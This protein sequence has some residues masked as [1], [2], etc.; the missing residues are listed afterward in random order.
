MHQ[1]EDGPQPEPEPC[2]AEF[3]MEFVPH[4]PGGRAAVPAERAGKFVWMIA[5]GQMT[6]Q[7]F[8]EMRQY[9]QHIVGTGMW[10][11]NWDG[12]P[13]PQPPKDPQEEPPQ[14]PSA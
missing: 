4:L 11:Q 10:Q 2:K 6:E 12:K 9:L 14:E 5:E 1:E 3:D 7:C 13:P 8:A